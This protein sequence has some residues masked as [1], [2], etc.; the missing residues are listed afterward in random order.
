MVDTA[1]LLFKNQVLRLIL[2][3]GK[4]VWG[5]IHLSLPTEVRQMK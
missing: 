1:P 4:H 3:R 2:G 5:V